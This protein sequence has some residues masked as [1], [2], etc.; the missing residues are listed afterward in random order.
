MFC[1]SVAPTERHRSE[2]AAP[3]RPIGSELSGLRS[4]TLSSRVIKTADLF[5]GG[6]GTSTAIIEVA[7]AFGMY[8]Q[9][10]GV[11]HWPLAIET[12]SLNHPRAVHFCEDLHSFN[13]RKY[14][15]EFELDAIWASPS[16]ISFSTARGGRPIDCDQDRATIWCVL[17][18]VEAILPSFLFIENVPEF[19]DYGPLDSNGR[20]IKSRK[21]ETYLAAINAIKSLGYR[22]AW[23][24]FCAAD[25]GDPTTRKR[26]FIQAVRGRRRI[27]WPNPTHARFPSQDLLSPPLRKWVAAREII[28]WSIE[29]KSIFNRDRPLVDKTM[30]RIWIGLEKF[31]ISKVISAH[32][33]ATFVTPNFG[34]RSGQTP[35]TH[36]IDE[37]LPA[38][39]SHGAGGLVQANLVEHAGLAPSPCAHKAADT[40]QPIS[41][42]IPEN[43]SFIVRYHGESTAES[44]DEPL[45][46]VEAGAIK[47]YVATCQLAPSTKGASAAVDDG[48][49]QDGA[50]LV[51]LKGTGVAND[52]GDPLHTVQ[53]GGLHHALVQSSLR[54]TM[55]LPQ[56]GGGQVRSEAEPLP[57]VA[58]KGA[59]SLVE[60]SL[61]E[62]KDG[63]LCGPEGFLLQVNHSDTGRSDGSHRVRSLG[64]P[65]PTVCGNRGEW[66][67]VD[68]TIRQHD[69]P[70]REEAGNAYTLLVRYFRTE[71]DDSVSE[72]VDPDKLVPFDPANEGLPKAGRM[73]VQFG[74]KLY[75]LFINFRML[76]P[77]E[78]ALGQG[79]RKGYQFRGNK[80]QVVKQIG[81]A[82]PRRLARAIVA[83]ALAQDADAPEK[84]LKWDEERLTNFG[85]S[86]GANRAAA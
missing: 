68:A 56:H 4:D 82:V 22:A 15:R 31:L 64:D 41:D 16:C 67:V 17:R 42:S 54:T 57:T 14:F 66:A 39:T 35:R 55:I 65:L 19:R 47:H 78:L 44:I 12:H 80:T 46:T 8:C 27:V 76:E 6:G 7:E 23:G 62:A 36:S 49:V 24:V 81:N 1:E 69:S 72:T 43:Q 28:D 2:V 75:E 59:I 10:T 25:Y 18:W 84:I 74:I 51:K 77:H 34:E 30:R 45:S 5:C 60:A 85:E 63:T 53:A 11:N 52:L 58:S 61:E 50:F 13:P 40:T 38:V 83:A 9:L 86:P 21:G 3:R 48:D 29:G 26:L 37:P 71:P 70:G 73:F 33:Q 32:S 20:P 79:F